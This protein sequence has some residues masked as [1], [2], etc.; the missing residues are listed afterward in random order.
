[1]ISRVKN[2]QKYMEKIPE[3]ERDYNN[4]IGSN[5]RILQVKKILK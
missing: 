3:L 5:F 1:M 2:S 4:V